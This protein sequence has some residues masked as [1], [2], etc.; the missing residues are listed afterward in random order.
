MTFLSPFN[1]RS[2]VFLMELFQA[3]HEIKYFGLRRVATGVIFL[4]RLDNDVDDIGEATAAAAAFFH[5]VIDLRRHDK[6]P[7]IFIEKIGDNLPD[8]LIGYIIAAADKHVFIP[9][10]TLTIVFSAKE[11]GGCQE[12]IRVPQH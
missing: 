11:D 6:L 12:K 9:N 1:V 2:P 8:F 4:G 10:M 7:T 3:G 5:G